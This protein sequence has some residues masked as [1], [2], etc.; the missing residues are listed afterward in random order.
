MSTHDV[1]SLLES[2]SGRVKQ[3]RCSVLKPTANV[4]EFKFA[5]FIADAKGVLRVSKSLLC[6]MGFY[7]LGA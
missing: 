1:Q 6:S 5:C 4:P 2:E 3:H 7:V